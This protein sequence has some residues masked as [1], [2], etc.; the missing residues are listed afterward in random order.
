MPKTY[1]ILLLSLFIDKLNKYE[2]A[3]IDMIKFY[4][5]TYTFETYDKLCEAIELYDDNNTREEA[6]KKY[7]KIELWDVSKITTMPYLFSSYSLN[8]D[9]SLWD[10]SNVIDMSDMF[11]NSDFTGD[12]S[13]WD[14]SKVKNMSKM[15]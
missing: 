12:I 4:I 13:N 9:F 11:A 3:I 14:V 8:Q 15:F 7:G 10:V 1:N 2:P 5:K 6:I